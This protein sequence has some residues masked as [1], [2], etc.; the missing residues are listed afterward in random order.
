[1]MKLGMFTSGYQRNPLEHCFQDAK[2]FGFVEEVISEEQ[3]GQ[4]GF[5]AELRRK[6]EGELKALSGTPDLKEQRYERFRAFGR[7]SL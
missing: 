3:L 2:E 6:L 7:S 4:P 1:M 5:Y